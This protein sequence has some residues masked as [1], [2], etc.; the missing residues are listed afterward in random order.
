MRRPPSERRTVPRTMTTVP[1]RIGAVTSSPSR[2]MARA[3]AKKGC[4]LLRAAAIAAPTFSML[5]NRRSRPVTVPMSPARTNRMTPAA[6]TRPTPPVKRTAAHSPTVPTAR[7]IQKPPNVPPEA[8]ALPDA[9]GRARRQERARQREQVC[10]AN[11]RLRRP[12]GVGGEPS[13]NVARVAVPREDRVEDLLDAPP[14]T[15][16]VRRLIKVIPS[17]SKVGSLSARVKR[18][19]SSVRSW[20]GRCSRS[21]ASRWYAVSCVLRP[22]TPRRRAQLAGWS[23]NAHDCG[24][25]PRAP[26]IASQ[27]RGGSWSGR[28]VRG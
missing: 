25:Q 9:D 17:T 6:E 21:A 20:N 3:V 27:P 5:T 14:S 28:P 22:N 19:L 26:G 8:Q 23:R 15:T 11:R 24:V 4:R 12:A 18:S 13:D 2:A 7:L 1:T 16:R 10:G